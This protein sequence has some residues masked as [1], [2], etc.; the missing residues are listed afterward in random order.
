MLLIKTLL[1]HPKPV[2]RYLTQVEWNWLNKVV[3]YRVDFSNIILSM[4]LFSLLYLYPPPSFR[5]YSLGFTPGM[6]YMAG[7]TVCA[8]QASKQTKL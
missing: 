6:R 5:S 7:T 8:V 4:L 3:Q 1:D 2:K